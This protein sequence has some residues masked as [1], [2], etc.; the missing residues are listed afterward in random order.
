MV[1][2]SLEL[3]SKKLGAWVGV[4]LA[5]VLQGAYLVSDIR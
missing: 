5:E 2:F 1:G 4:F 3:G